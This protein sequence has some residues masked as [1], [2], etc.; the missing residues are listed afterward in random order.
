VAD[1]FLELFLPEM[2]SRRIGDPLGPETQ[3]GPQAR[4]DLRAHLH[5]QVQESVQRGA[6]VLLGGELPEG[7]GFFY[8]PT[9]LVAVWVGNNDNTPMRPYLVSGVTGAA[10][11]WHALME[12][13]TE[14][15]PS[16]WPEKPPEIIGLDVCSLSGLLPNPQQPCSTRHEFFI[17]GFETSQMETPRRPI[18]IKKDTGLP[19]PPGETEN[20]ELQERLVVSDPFIQDF[21]L[22][23]PWPQEIDQNGQPTGKIFYPETT[24][25]T[26]TGHPPSP[27]GP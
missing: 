4:A 15:K 9:V 6:R 2:G 3:I 17:K 19:P 21:C 22:D 8:P 13:V 11:I 27:T 10:P 1:R 18:W 7:P 26:T 23:C 12:K 25:D 5:R 20:L 24:I 16:E 14:D